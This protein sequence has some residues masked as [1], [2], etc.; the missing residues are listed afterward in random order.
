MALYILCLNIF[1]VILFYFTDEGHAL[2]L[3]YILKDTRMIPL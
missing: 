2:Y 1:C 3:Q